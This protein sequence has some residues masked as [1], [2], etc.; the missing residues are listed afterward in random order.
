M[1]DGFLFKQ[2]VNASKIDQSED[3]MLVSHYDEQ[4]SSYQSMAIDTKTLIASLDNDMD[5]F[6]DIGDA[7]YCD[8]SEFALS[9]HDHDIYTSAWYKPDDLDGKE[10]FTVADIYDN[11]HQQ[12]QTCIQISV[13]T[14]ESIVSTEWSQIISSAQPKI[15]TL[16]PL[17]LSTFGDQSYTSDP[18]LSDFNGWVPADGSKYYLSIF[19]SS[20]STILDSIYGNG[21]NRTFTVPDM[22]GFAK[23]SNDIGQAWHPALIKHHVAL[24]KH[25]HAAN[26]VENKQLKIEITKSNMVPQEIRLEG[27]EH[28]ALTKHR[29]HAGTSANK[30]QGNATLNCTNNINKENLSAASFNISEQPMITTIPDDYVAYPAFNYV[31][32]MIYIGRSLSST[33]LVA[34]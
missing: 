19:P 12:I 22:N 14:D 33:P 13:C 7:V 20:I 16:Q 26:T 21:D 15:G 32:M 9:S 29:M 1:A 24:K 18:E 6:I 2:L 10:K 31:P 34:I 23:I 27:Y 28:P 25:T 5:Q 11:A 4:T 3:L 8:S 30:P 17:A